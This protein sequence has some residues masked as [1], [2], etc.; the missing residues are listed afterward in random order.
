MPQICQWGH[1]RAQ[2]L[3]GESSSPLECQNRGVLASQVDE[4]RP[5]QP[6]MV[7]LDLSLIITEGAAVL[8]PAV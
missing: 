1:N 4:L 2:L 3:K 7:K 5:K 6:P 8:C